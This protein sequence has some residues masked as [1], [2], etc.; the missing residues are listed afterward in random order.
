MIF[1]MQCLCLFA[2]GAGLYF[3][4]EVWEA[5]T[6]QEPSSR[7]PYLVGIAGLGLVIIPMSILLFFL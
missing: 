6:D 3:L 2:I 1:F 5:R 7:S 4:L